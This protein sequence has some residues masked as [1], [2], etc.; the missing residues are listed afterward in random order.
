M[1]TGDVIISNNVCVADFIFL[2]MAYSPLFTA[3]AINK[4]TGKF[5]FRK[6][7]LFETLTHAM[8]IKFPKEVES[9]QFYDDLKILVNS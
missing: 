1:Q 2:E 4:D 9:S 8:G 3:V 5:G 7:G 6:L